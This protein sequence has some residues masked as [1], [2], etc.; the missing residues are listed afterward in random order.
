MNNDT[1]LCRS[2]TEDILLI[3]ME[4]F[5]YWMSIYQFWDS[6]HWAFLKKIIQLFLKT[7]ESIAIDKAGISEV[8][9]RCATRLQRKSE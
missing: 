5:E 7:R 2:L 1:E 3:E 9:M 6:D 4:S 8:W